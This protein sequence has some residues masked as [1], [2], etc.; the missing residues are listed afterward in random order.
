MTDAITIRLSTPADDSALRE[1]AELDGGRRPEGDVLVAEV[2]G[3]S[4]AAIGMDGAVVAD[5]FKPSADAVRLLRRQLEGLPRRRPR[6][7]RRAASGL[8]PRLG[9][10]RASSGCA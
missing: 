2:G 5:P 10:T 7:I 6:L 3:R 9:Q 8:A 1:L 4:W